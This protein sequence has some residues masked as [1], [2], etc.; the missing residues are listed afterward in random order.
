[1]RRAHG[2]ITALLTLAVAAPAAAQLPRRPYLQL[3]T[4]DGVTI[5]WR[6][7]A[8]V[9]SAV[10]YGASVDA[11]D[12]PVVGTRT[13]VGG[14]FG[15]HE[16]RV[17][18]LSPATTYYYAVGEGS[19][20]PASAGDPNQHFTTSPLPGLPTPFRFWVV[21]DSGNGSPGQ[22]AVFDA[23]RAEVGDEPPD[24]FVHVGDMAYNDGTTGQFDVRFYGVYADLL[25]NTVA[26]PAIG[27][28]EGHTSDSGTE[29][30]PYY[31]GYV[32]PRAGEAGG[33]PSGTEAYYSFDYANV[34]FI[35]LD[36]YDSPRDP[37]GPMV[38]WLEMDLAAATADWIVAYWH[39]PPYTDGSHVDSEN[40]QQGMRRFVLPV[41]EAGGV[42]L[43]F[44]GH[45]H[46][47]E[48]S[49]LLH[50]GYH[51]GLPGPTATDA[52]VDMGDGRV[53][54]DGPY[55]AVGDGAVYVVAGHGGAGV[56]GGASHPLMY[57]SEVANGSVLVD[58]SGDSL[59]LRNVRSD[60]VITDEATIVR[61]DGVFVTRPSG[62]SYLAGS[63]VEVTWSS[64][65]TSGQVRIEYSLDDGASWTL[66]T[67]STDDDGTFTWT[68]PRR[69]TT[70][71]RVRITDVAAPALSGTSPRPFTLAAEADVTLV[72][73]GSTWEYHDDGTA[74]PADWATDAAG[75]WPTGPAQLGYGDGDE[76]TVLLDADPNVPSVYFRRVLDLAAPP[77]D[78]A[79]DVT[80]DDGFA[81]YVNGVLAGS[82]NAD[83]LAHDAYATGMSSDNER[84]TLD[85]DPSAFVTGANVI[86]VVVKQT[87]ATSS[88][89]S[90][91]LAL[92]GRVR[93][94]LDPTPEDAGVPDLD[95]GAP[96]PGEDAGP[97]G[98]G[99]EDAGPDGGGEDGCGCR[100]AGG[101]PGGL[102]GWLAALGLAVTLR[103]RRSA[104]GR[105]SRL[106][107]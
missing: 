65:G 33:I 21:G 37:T 75:G 53:A 24:L 106:V 9:P 23:M 59:T 97:S 67:A 78:V 4:E 69:A 15:Q 12:T 46:I 42:D 63:D 5:V 40:E 47:Y 32:L 56:S 60:G 66:V 41:L 1:M 73:A 71:G 94:P 48:R 55:Q 99:T 2:S 35:V 34:H 87:S 90:F 76:A 7:D 20:P 61:G 98:G 54:G 93:V 14:G 6:T 84:V 58:V 31:E 25:E 27:N 52:I 45:S 83:D 22:Y 107:G 96:R 50:G 68:A 92:A 57:F 70:A 19:C 80:F 28:H 77:I 11:L 44:G 101:A 81:L 95:A 104:G 26:W 17:S 85:L 64:S 89:L 49:Y 74:P 43:V 100:A 30:G 18:G 102:P 82:R 105:R 3:G 36:S 10:C 51:V 91:D 13:D 88:D 16:V 39:H 62:R 103:R 38:R 72:P 29:S 8:D 86:A 79:A